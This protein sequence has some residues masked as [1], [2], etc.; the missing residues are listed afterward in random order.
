MRT[1]GIP[2]VTSTST[3][4]GAPRIPTSALVAIESGI[5]TCCTRRRTAKVF[6]LLPE[7]GDVGDER[8]G[9]TFKFTRPSDGTLYRN[10]RARELLAL[11]HSDLRTREFGQEYD[12]KVDAANLITVII[13]ETECC[14]S[15]E[16]CRLNLFTPLALKCGKDAAV[17]STDVSANTE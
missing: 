14:K 2:V 12:A 17:I 5:G 4:T 10:E 8:G 9:P 13:Q 11:A 16:R 3:S 7:R 6:G 15:W 1:A